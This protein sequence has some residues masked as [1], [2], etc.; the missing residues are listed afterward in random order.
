MTWEKNGKN[1]AAEH[2]GRRIIIRH[3]HYHLEESLKMNLRQFFGIAVTVFFALSA[4]TSFA[5][6]L[7]P[8]QAAVMQNPDLNGKAFNINDYAGKTV[9]VSFF[10]SGCNVCSRDLKLMREFY[11]NNKNKKFVL[12]A[13]SLDTSKDDFSDYVQLID[14]S[15]PKDQHFPIIWRAASGHNDNFGAITHK[16]THFVIDAKGK[17]QIKREGTFLAE[18][19]DKLWETISE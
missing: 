3:R 15:V 14:L 2:I 6:Q 16:P 12:L 10:T 8:G 19:W 5:Q 7:K 18:D 1:F 9:L 11:V 4:N 13:V 17:L